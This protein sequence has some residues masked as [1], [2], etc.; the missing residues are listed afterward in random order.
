MPDE[1]YVTYQSSVG[2]NNI[3][4]FSGTY[5]VPSGNVGCYIFNVKNYNTVSRPMAGYTLHYG[6]KANGHLT[7]INEA[8]ISDCDYLV[9]TDSFGGNGVISFT[10]S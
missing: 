3:S 9:Y 8:N 10:F 4:A 2:G 5:T 1:G 6:I 7:A